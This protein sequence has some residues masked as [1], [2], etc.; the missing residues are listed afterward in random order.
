M[1]N[2]FGLILLA[3]LSVALGIGLVISRKQAAD[4]QRDDLDRIGT[5]SNKWVSTSSA[6]E[7]ERKTSA[8]LEKDRTEKLA[9]LEDLTNSYLR[10]SA[11]LS[12]ASANLAKTEQALKATEEEVK[13]RDAKIAELEGQNQALDKQALD[14]SAAITNL[15]TQIAETERK[16]SASEGDK[17]FLQ[18]ELKR[19]MAEKA[20]L[21]RQFND[22]VV[23]RAQVARLKE[24][25]S[26]ARRIE[27]IRRGI[28]AGNDQRGATKL[29][30]GLN[31][32][33]PPPKPQP[34][35]GDLNVEVTSEGTVRVVPPGTNSPTSTSTNAPR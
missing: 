20:E 1:S 33:K 34:A 27:W 30:Q 16:L 25:L 35:A 28:F 10:V 2:R 3:L 31:A 21:E 11:N 5:L 14:L 24:E 9:V 32:P 17:A 13:K 6:L 8:N 7:E 15:T 18:K 29:M 23:L 22:L 4:R 26:I 19:L 12:Q